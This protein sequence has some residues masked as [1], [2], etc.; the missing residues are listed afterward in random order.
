[1]G[2]LVVVPCAVLSGVVLGAVMRAPVHYALGLGVFFGIIALLWLGK[3][4]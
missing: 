4:K 2:K 1:M 3:A